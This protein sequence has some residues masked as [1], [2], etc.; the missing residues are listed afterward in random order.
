MISQN[1]AIIGSGSGFYLFTAKPL[2]QPMVI[3]CQ[4][5]P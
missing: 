3:Y 4:L 2:L 1:F 5:D